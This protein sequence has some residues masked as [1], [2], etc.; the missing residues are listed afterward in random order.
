MI[1]AWTGHRPD[2][3]ADASTA[4]ATVV[5]TARDLLHQ[6]PL[7]RFLVGGQRGVD[8]WAAE[9]AVDFGVPFTVVL[10]FDVPD[11]TLDWTDTDRD[12]LLDSLARA[13]QVRVA[14]GYSERNRVL[15]AEA[16]LLVA[17]WT[18]RA[19][20]GTAETLAFAQQFA[21]PIRDVRL[22][23]SPSTG[24]QAGRGI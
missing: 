6:E 8:T 1:V 2:L 24:R 12:R 17:V 15:A 4:R 18:G 9:A 14:G 11:F 16:D 10:P 21:T 5:D 22:T 19:G 20:G 23:A 13:D 7:E 3:F